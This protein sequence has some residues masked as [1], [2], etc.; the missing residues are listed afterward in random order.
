MRKILCLTL[1]TA[2]M[3]SCATMKPT[4]QF[5]IAVFMDYRPYADGGF[6]I[7]P[8]PY[9]GD[10]I[11]L[12]ELRLDVHPAKVPATGAK[13][14]NSGGKFEDAV[15]SQQSGVSGLVTYPIDESKLLDEF[16]T[17]AKALGGDGVSSFKCVVIYDSVYQTMIDHYTLSGLI[18]DRL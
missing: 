17:K 3:V 11:S 16:V 14:R 13:V 6:F 5:S 9:P 10:Y 1:A 8:E 12:G 7:S 18:I 2:C 15:Y 4:E